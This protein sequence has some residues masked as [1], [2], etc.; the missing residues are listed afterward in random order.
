MTH[1]NV[2][3]RTV[4][5][6]QRLISR[7]VG[8]A[9]VTR[10]ASTCSQAADKFKWHRRDCSLLGGFGASSSSA[11]VISKFTPDVMAEMSAEDK[12]TMGSDASGEIVG[13][14]KPPRRRSV[15]DAAAASARRRSL[16]GGA[17]MGSTHGPEDRTWLLRQCT[18]FDFGHILKSRVVGAGVRSWR[19]DTTLCKLVTDEWLF[20]L[21]GHCP[22]LAS[23]DLSGCSL[24]TGPGLGA[25][26]SRVC[27]YEHV[28]FL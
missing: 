8:L 12:V 4:L 3:L 27:S 17:G 26:F 15:Q 22:N 28:S 24:V 20:A 23:L 11:L 6:H 14:P 21:A 10:V 7:C 19:F 5:R 13:A 16:G 18:G 1:D 25:A 9:S 2:Q